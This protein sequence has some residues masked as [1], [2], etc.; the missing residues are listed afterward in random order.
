[1]VW[2]NCNTAF[3]I[4]PDA[5]EQSTALTQSHRGIYASVLSTFFLRLMV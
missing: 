2:F 5:D 3:S 1:M 4:T